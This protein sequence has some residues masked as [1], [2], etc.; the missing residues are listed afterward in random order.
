M[1]LAAVWILLIAGAFA[2]GQQ[3]GDSPYQNR[4]RILESPEPLLADFPEYFE[5]ITEET[6]LEAPEN[7]NDAN[8]DLH[9][10]ACRFS[11][12]ARG[13]IEMPKLLSARETAVIMVHPWAIEDRWGWK[14]QEPN[15]VADFCT[16]VKM[17]WPQSI[18]KRLWIP[19]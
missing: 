5:P 10:R 3:A 17:R 13:I 16:P 19:S 6:P 18:P 15:G 11:Y 9:V 1:R 12:N 14:T 2:F 8:A 7:M 4:L